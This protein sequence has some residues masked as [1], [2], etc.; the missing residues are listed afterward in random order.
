MERS[1]LWFKCAALHDP[2][3]PVIKK[4]AVLGWKA[5]HRQVD[6][7]LER[8]FRGDELLKRMKGWFTADVSKVIEII[9]QYGKLKVID[10]TDLVVETDAPAVTESLANS[11]MAAFGE[12]VWIE[13]ITKTRLE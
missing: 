1:M 3:R 9:D 13:P 4:P 12:E 10:D 5:K 8:L 2:V 11:L 7:V 6:L